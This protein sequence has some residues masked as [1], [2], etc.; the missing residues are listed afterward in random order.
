MVMRF[1][2][3]LVV[4]V[5]SSISRIVSFFR[6]VFNTVFCRVERGLLDRKDII[7]TILFSPTLISLIFYTL[8]F[9]LEE[10]LSISMVLSLQRCQSFIYLNTWRAKL[11]KRREHDAPQTRHP[12]HPNRASLDHYHQHQI[13]S[14]PNQPTKPPSSSTQLSYP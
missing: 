2:L 6:K 13:Q 1:F 12:S 10:K 4:V 3:V 14:S 7:S 8:W 11:T 9:P 5:P